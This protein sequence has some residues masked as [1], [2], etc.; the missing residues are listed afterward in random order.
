VQNAG[1]R[2]VALPPLAAPGFVGPSDYKETERLKL[3]QL[4]KASA[5]RRNARAALEAARVPSGTAAALLNGAAGARNGTTTT[6]AAS[7]LLLGGDAQQQQQQPVSAP[8]PGALPA[9]IVITEG[10][11]GK[12]LDLW[13][14]RDWLDDGLHLKPPAYDKIGEVVAGTIAK[15]LSIP[16]EAVASAWKEVDAAEAKERGKKTSAA[17]VVAAGAKEGG[18]AAARAAAAPSA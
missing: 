2:I 15:A 16:D 7:R 13:T 1:A 12:S 4:I 5:A 17:V 14:R 10:E 8:M 18:E 6:V 11:P 3:A 9:M